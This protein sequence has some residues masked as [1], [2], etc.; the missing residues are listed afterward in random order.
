MHPDEREA[1]MDS[2]PRPFVDRHH[3][4]VAESSRHDRL[5]GEPSVVGCLL[6]NRWPVNCRARPAH[7]EVGIDL[8]TTNSVVCVLE[9]GEP[10]VITNTEGVVR[11]SRSSSRADRGPQGAL[12][13]RTAREVAARPRSRRCL[14]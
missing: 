7:P 9:G 5:H 3:G 14:G 4:R 11:P 1:L 12:V 13:S 2:R 8:G 6:M 10:T